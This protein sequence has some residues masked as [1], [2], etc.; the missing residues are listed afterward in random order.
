MLIL[1]F[2]SGLFSSIF[3]SGKD[4]CSEDAAKLIRVTG[5]EPKET[6]GYLRQ[7]PLCD[8]IWQAVYMAQ[9]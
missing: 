9:C 6:A 5:R 4:G 3:V 8:R 2:S 7:F 1:V